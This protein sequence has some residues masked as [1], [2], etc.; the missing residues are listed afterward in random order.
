MSVGVMG[1]T[2]SPDTTVLL[3]ELCSGFKALN[4]RLDALDRQFDGLGE[5]IDRHKTRLDTTEGRIS[6]LEDGAA[7]TTK[8]VEHLDRIM[9]TVAV[10]NEDLE[11]RSRRNNVFI[12]GI[13]ESTNTGRL[14]Q[15]VEGLLTDLFGSE[16]FA[17]TFVVEQAHRTLGPRPSLGCPPRPILARLLNFKD[18]DMALRLAREA[19]T[20]F[21]QGS[22]VSIYPDV[23][24]LVQDARR[25]FAGASLQE[26]RLQCRS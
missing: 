22:N 13:P 9:K 8:R 10:K 3:L 12:M 4:K 5:W 24:A 7:Q 18:R 2:A 26:R 1:G 21:W 25:K 20:L 15:F 23:T 6:D 17:S 11:A 14:H 16:Q 19:E